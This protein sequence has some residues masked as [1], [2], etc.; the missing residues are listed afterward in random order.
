MEAI[1]QAIRN[2]LAKADAAN[3]AVRQ[4]IYESA[5]TAHERSL[6]ANG[7]LDEQQR[8][9]RRER[10]KATITRVENGA[11]A[12]QP[13]LR[14]EPS[15][16]QEPAVPTVEPAARPQSARPEPAFA[17]APRGERREPVLGE[18]EALLGT[19]DLPAGGATTADNYRP[20]YRSRRKHRQSEGSRVGGLRK[21]LIVAALLA[22]ALGGL[23]YVASGLIAVKPSTTAASNPPASGSHEPLK[24]GQL[25][26]EGTWIEIFGPADTSQVSVSGRATASIAGDQ[27]QKFL[28]VKSP[29]EA[30]EISF[31]VGPGV[32]QQIAGKKAV[33]DILAKTEGPATQMAVS[34]DFGS[35]GD[36]GRKR[37]DVSDA[38]SEY[39]VQVE[40]PAGSGNGTGAIK[41]NS[42]ISGA[43]KSVDILAIRLQIMN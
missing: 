4:K 43:G 11:A 36:C 2:A 10:L 42:D 38:T 5:W 41:I 24:E 21:F 39:L 13:P 28:R 17:D 20:D 6:A 31:A 30:D 34:C 12:Q 16:R 9:E 18:D 1:E 35:A 37:Y 29:G 27:A 3:P 7:A 23:W 26:P 33:F 15:G 40:L 22:V 14:P 8:N 25:P 32:L 19:P